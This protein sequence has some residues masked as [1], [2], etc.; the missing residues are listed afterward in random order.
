MSM[1]KQAPETN[2]KPGMKLPE[3]SVRRPTTT[4]AMKLAA[5]PI[6]RM[7]AQTA[8]ALSG[9]ERKLQRDREE[10]RLIYPLDE[11]GKD[12]RRIDGQTGRRYDGCDSAR[13]QKKARPDE[14]RATLSRPCRYEP[15]QQAG[16]YPNEGED[17]D[18]EG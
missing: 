16:G 1:L 5:L 11:A 18:S 6:V 3:R 7:A 12:D 14:E 8:P 9:E 13:P 10:R 17:G 4:G 15:A 2:R